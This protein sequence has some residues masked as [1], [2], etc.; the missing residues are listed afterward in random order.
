MPA[1]IIGVGVEYFNPALFPNALPQNI[2]LFFDP[3]SGIG[4]YWTDKRFGPPNQHVTV[5]MTAPISN[6]MR[7]N[8]ITIADH[9]TQ[10]PQRGQPTPPDIPPQIPFS[11]Q[12]PV[13]LFPPIVPPPPPIPFGYPQPQPTP[14]PRRFPSPGPVPPG[15]QPLPPWF[16]LPPGPQPL[17]PPGPIPPPPGPIPP[18]P[19][20]VPPPVSPIPPPGPQP[21]PMPGPG[22]FPMP[23]PQPTPTPSPLTIQPQPQPSPSETSIQLRPQPTP[24]PDW[25]TQ[26][27][28]WRQT[29]PP[30]RGDP[31]LTKEIPQTA[32]A[33]GQMW[34]PSQ[35]ETEPAGAPEEYETDTVTCPHCGGE[36]EVSAPVTS[37]GF[38]HVHG[39]PD[40]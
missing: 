14:A 18:G 24:Q 15:P 39:L 38:Q 26:Y 3:A 32:G 29:D 34:N 10:I 8:R 28:H 19:Q 22:P 13:V 17:P 31:Y 37:P 21:G 1:Q 7:I 2:I 40:H 30:L 5:N 35:D 4:P 20:P 36:R 6:A 27:I 9:V 33:V 23:T 16:P 11:P 25:V 12:L